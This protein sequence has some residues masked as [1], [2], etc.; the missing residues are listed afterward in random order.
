MGIYIFLIAI[1]FLFYIISYFNEK[2][3]YK[4]YF[5]E[6]FL[7]CLIL[8]FGFMTGSDW[9]TYEEIYNSYGNNDFF[10]RFSYLEPGYLLLNIIGN[11]IG[12]NFWEWYI[13]LRVIIFFIV[14]KFLFFYCPRKSLLICYTIFLGM[15][16]IMYYIDPSFRNMLAASVS[17]IGFK[18]IIN[19]NKIK[20]LIVTIIALSFH[21]S[22]IFLPLIYVF[23]ILNIS[24]TKLLII[25][26]II[27]IIF[28]SKNSI[29]IIIDNLFSNL[30]FV[31]GKIENYSSG[32]ESDT[33]GSGK[34]ISITYLFNCFIFVLLLVNREFL[35][36]FKYGKIIFN[37][38]ILYI[39]MS[40]IGLTVLIFTRFYLY[41]LYFMAIAISILVLKIKRTQQIIGA[42]FLFIVSVISNYKQMQSWRFIP[43]SNIILYLDNLPSF[44][45]RSDYNL[46]NSPYKDNL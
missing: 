45:Y 8:C 25:F 1:T 46:I 21:F 30:E 42:T 39:F 26:V 23:S 34:I 3:I 24:N 19:R 6:T 31:Q 41:I 15:W 18:Y 28:I 38:A 40:R 44:E 5:I 27:N 29:F 36:K 43:Y 16:G 12:L 10:W 22:A 13:I 4:L 32:R 14:C 11:V 2:L 17:I 37:L 35:N 33:V 20:Y 9:R 7:S